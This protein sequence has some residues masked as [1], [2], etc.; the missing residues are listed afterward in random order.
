MARRNIASIPDGAIKT[1]VLDVRQ[2]TNFSCGAASLHAVC[3]YWGVGPESEYDYMKALHTDPNMGTTPDHIIAYAK[4]RGLE[5]EA[6]EGMTVDEL[7][8]HLDKGH[9]V[10]VLIQAWGDKKKYR[11]YDENGHYVVAIGY[12][13]H[14]IYFEEPVLLGIRAYLTY[15][16]F[17]QRW[18]DKDAFGKSYVRYGMAMWKHGKPEYVYKAQKIE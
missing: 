5:V 10:I 18:H 4:K 7:K 13:D 3:A 15:K 2:N 16:E 1:D 11:N 9:P 6:K 12:D 17:D 14:R 8:T